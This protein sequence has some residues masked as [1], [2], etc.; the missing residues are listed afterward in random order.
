MHYVRSA[1]G[2]SSEVL[3]LSHLRGR[4]SPGAPRRNASPQLGRS[5]ESHCDHHWAPF[6][7]GWAIARLHDIYG[8]IWVDLGRN[9]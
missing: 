6:Q 3:L 9:R 7:L 5:V 2:R 1:V 8:L 4:F